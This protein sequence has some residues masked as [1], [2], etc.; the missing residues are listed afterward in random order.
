MIQGTIPQLTFTRFVAAIAVVI[1]HYGQSAFPFDSGFS[2]RVAGEAGFTVSYFFFLSGFLLYHVYSR[3]AFTF[4]DFF[5]ARL[6]RI[7]PLY[8]FA[9]AITL[10]GILVLLEQ[11]PWGGTAI[12][13]ALFLQ[14][15][16][17]GNSLTINYP[18][19]SV[20]IEM[21]FYLS[22]PL[23]LLATKRM[24]ENRFIV[25]AIILW[26]TSIGQNIVTQKL[27]YDPTSSEAGDFIMYFP[28]WHLN[29]FVCGM[30][31]GIIFQRIRNR[32]IRF[33][34]PIATVLVALVL[35]M[36][37][38]LD[39]GF[40]HQIMHT[41]LLSPLYAIV[42]IG[43]ALDK[44]VLVKVF[45]WKPFQFLGEI[46]Y[47]I[48]LLQYP[49]WIGFAYSG[50]SIKSTGEFYTYVATLIAASAAVYWLLERPA[51]KYIRQRFKSSA[52]EKV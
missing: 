9:F 4:R 52:P 27:Y 39:K 37:I 38:V 40:A 15:W 32:T 49:V 3:K 36:M 11:K 29:T 5:V 10:F 34:V 42:V 48:Y 19:W 50:C 16:F 43:L 28:L 35:I 20:S 33:Y 17:P 8:W 47:G 30:A 31:A 1:F 12:L 24:G 18:A 2:H 6:A 14:A 21:F 51:R 22:F 46:S 7:A 13:Q 44:W 23:L 45:S 26:L 25:F 41:G